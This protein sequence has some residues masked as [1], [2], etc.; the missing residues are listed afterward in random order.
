MGNTNDQLD[1]GGGREMTELESTMWRANRHPEN[2]TQGG[3]LEVLAGSPTWSE[4]RQWHVYGLAHYPRF[5]QRVVEPALPVGPPVWAD[6]ADFDLDHHLRRVQLPAPGTMDQLLEVCQTWAL[7]Q[8]DPNRPPW[9]GVFVEGLEGGRSAYFL[10]VHHCLMDGF[11]S[12]QLLADLHG[13]PAAAAAEYDERKEA[14]VAPGGWTVA[15]SQTVSRAKGLPGLV[16]KVV[17][18]AA[19][20]VKDPRQTAGF[21]ASVGRVLASPPASE[22]PLLKAGERTNWRF[23]TLSVDL[24]TLKAAGKSVGGTINDAYVASVLGGLRL[25]HE[26]E[27]APIGDV[28]INMPVSMRRD[29]DSKGGNK[30]VPAFISA[31]SSIADPAERM[32][33]LRVTVQQVSSEPAL[34]VFSLV[35][36]VINRAPAAVLTPVFTGMQNR[37]D[38]TISNVPGLPDRSKFLGHDVEGIYYLAP[39]PGS[40]VMVVLHSHGGT[41]YIGVNCDGD[42]FDHRKLVAFLEDGFNEVLALAP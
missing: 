3:V 20:A 21:V 23:G 41:A 16:G 13:R 17:A 5:K 36:P 42:V 18:T 7:K 39:L 2:S 8:L 30:F 12:V 29:G 14:V 40:P 11:G 15:A 37:T 19:A 27:G 33:A 26:A 6:D 28:V 9:T 24:A 35:L 38:V 10:I 22:S 34:D 32:R 4:V 31:P 25:Y 1:W